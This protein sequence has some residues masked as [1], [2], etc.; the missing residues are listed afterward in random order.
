MKNESFTVPLLKGISEQ[1]PQLQDSLS[2]LENWRTD[3]ISNGWTNTLGYERYFLYRNDYVP[4]TNDKVDSLFYYTKHQG[5]LDSIIIEQGGTLSQVFDFDSLPKLRTIS[6]NRT[7]PSAN[8]INTQ[9]YQYG[10]FLFCTNGYDAPMKFVA[11]VVT[12]EASSDSIVVYPIGFGQKP[13]APQVWGIETDITLTAGTTGDVASMWRSANNKYDKGLGSTTSG[14]TNK[15][16]YKVAFISNTG[17]QSPL[18]DASGIVSWTTPATEY[19]Y[20]IPVEITTG[21]KGIIA[22]V[23]YRT[24]NMGSSTDE[25]YYYVATIPNNTETMF[26]D[27]VSD[28]SL[29]AQAPSESDSILFPAN[30]PRYI[31]SYKDCLFIDGGINN[32]TTLFYSKPNRPDQYELLNYVNIDSNNGGGVT[33]LFSYFNFLLVFREYAIDIIGGDYPNFISTNLV[34][35]IGTSATNTICS[36]YNLGIIFLS[37]DGVYIVSGNLQYGSSP[38]VTKIS[39]PIQNT[40]NRIN[41]D[42]LAKAS[43]TY[44]YKH[45]EWVCFVPID[46]ETHNTLAIVF[47][48]DR[49]QWSIRTGFP[50]SN[51]ITNKSGDIIFGHNQDTTAPQECGLF[52]ISDRRALGSTLGESGFTYNDPP[53]SIMRSAWLDMGDASYKKK[54]HYVYLLVATGGDQ[55]VAMTYYTDYQYNSPTTTPTQTKI[56]VSD[57]PSQ[58]T[59]DNVY[60]DT[61]KYWEERLYT[62]I[63]FDVHSKACS[64]FQWEI[65]TTKDMIVVGYMIDYTANGQKNIVGKVV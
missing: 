46:G 28:N 24:T 34:R 25:I 31:T 5:A 42:C 36:I 65:Q 44:S 19:R 33:G 21:E 59:Y 60:L 10:R 1:E 57:I 23:I 6:N 49:Q 12:G 62:A 18:S 27:D 52:V 40:I 58:N 8:E 39:T 63:R 37:S 13:T 30:K 50:A 61:G 54:V 47:H 9:Y 38:D 2:E 55:S 3:T 20:I 16:R 15:Y 4:F 32:N 45:K 35:Y 11:K 17:S 64:F 29:G 56:Q 51:V 48:T 7:I 14:D 22:R 53:T 26:F 43:A 41:T